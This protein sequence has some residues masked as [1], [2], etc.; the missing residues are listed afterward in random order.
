MSLFW[1]LLEVRMDCQEYHLYDT[2]IQR[3]PSCLFPRSIWCKWF[4]D[5]WTLNA[6]QWSWHRSEWQL[7]KLIDLC[8]TYPTLL[9]LC[10]L[11]TWIVNT[12]MFT[13]VCLRMLGQIV[14]DCTNGNY[15]FAFLLFSV[16]IKCKWFCNVVVLRIKSKCVRL[17]GCTSDTW[18]AMIDANAVLANSADDT[19]HQLIT[20]NLWTHQL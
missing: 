18:T 12:M 10:G 1:T 5:H 14:K 11:N 20:A 17:N 19:G 3:L 4:F 9:D 8:H 13:L 7:D 6:E 16:S 15:V 2:S